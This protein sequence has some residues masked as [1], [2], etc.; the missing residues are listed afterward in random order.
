MLIISSRRPMLWGGKGCQ[1]LLWGVGWEGRGE[2]RVCLG[3]RYASMPAMAAQICT[4]KMKSMKRIWMVQKG[5]RTRFSQGDLRGAPWGVNLG[6]AAAAAHCGCGCR[7]FSELESADSKMG[8]RR[9]SLSFRKSCLDVKYKERQGAEIDS[10]SNGRSTAIFSESS[11]AAG[12]S[13]DTYLRHTFQAET[14]T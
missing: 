14:A 5:M 4:P 11:A 8:N 1:L 10:T 3:E 13:H 2:G 6:I 9:Y 12:D 7:M